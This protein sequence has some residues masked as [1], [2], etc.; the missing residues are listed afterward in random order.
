MEKARLFQKELLGRLNAVAPVA[1][2]AAVLGLDAQKLPRQ[3]V[4]ERGEQE[5]VRFGVL[6]C[7][8]EHAPRG[9]AVVVRELVV[10]S[11]A[12]R[13]AAAEPRSKPRQQHGAGFP[14]RRAHGV[15]PEGA[16]EL[17]SLHR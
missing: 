1:L 7:E 9:V 11:E 10:I 15:L 6:R 13:S 4:I 17:K 8:K 5:A 3:A 2:T 16:G 12:V 14:D